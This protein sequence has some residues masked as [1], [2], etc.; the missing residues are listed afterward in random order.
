MPNPVAVAH[1]STVT[2][3]AQA[4][5]GAPDIAVLADGRYVIV[6]GSET[7]VQWGTPPNGQPVGDQD[8]WARILDVNGTGA[9]AFEIPATPDPVLPPDGPSSG[10][11]PLL[12]QV[13][14][15]VT[16]LAN[17]GFAVVWG[18]SNAV[19]NIQTV[20]LRAFGSTGVGGGDIVVGTR[21]PGG[22]GGQH[23]VAALT[24]GRLVVAW[25]QNL[26]FDTFV[27]GRLIDITGAGGASFGLGGIIDG[28]LDL[29]N[30]F[31]EPNGGFGIGFS[32]FA[33]RSFLFSEYSTAG[34]VYDQTNT[35]IYSQYGSFT[36]NGYQYTNLPTAEAYD[37][38]AG[39]GFIRTFYAPPGL[40]IT[41]GIHL[42]LSTQTSLADFHI[43]Y[44]R[45]TDTSVTRLA[46]GD[47]AVI[48]AAADRSING[49][50]V[51][52]AGALGAVFQVDAAAGVAAKPVVDALPSGGF[53]VAWNDGGVITSQVYDVAVGPDITTTAAF[54]ITENIT[55]AGTVA[56][57]AGQGGAITY[58]LAAA[59]GSND[60][61]LFAINAA[62]GALVFLTAP[63]FENPQ[64]HGSFFPFDNTYAVDVIATEAGGYSDSATIEVTVI[65][66]QNTITGTPGNDSTAL[67]GS[68][69]NG[70]AEE[71]TINALAGN[72]RLIG[73]GGDDILNG[74]A[75]A[76]R[77]EG[78]GGT[79]TATY[80]DADSGIVASLILT[81]GANGDAAGDTYNSIE[82][83]IGSGFNDLL[84]GDNSNNRIQGG[85]GYDVIYGLN[86]SNILEGGALDD[87]YIST[88]TDGI[89][90]IV[91]LFGGGLDTVY[92]NH[93]FALAAEVEQLVLFGTPA[94]GTGSDGNNLLAGNTNAGV[95]LDGAGGDDVI[96]GS[97]FADTLIGGAGNDVLLGDGGGDR[98]DGGA[99]TD[100]YISTSADDTFVDTGSYEGTNDGFDTVYASYNFVN[101]GLVQQIILFGAA[102][103]ATGSA[104]NDILVGA[105]VTGP[106]TLSGLDGWDTLFG[107]AQSGDV[108]TGGD[109]SDALIG[110]AGADTFVFA[111]GSGSDTIYDFVPTSRGPAHDL[112]D[113][114]AYNTNYEALT[115]FDFELAHVASSYINLPNVGPLLASIALYGVVAADLQESD[116]VFQHAVA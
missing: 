60:N 18:Q 31:A 113:L 1:G 81:S 8:V 25:T 49:R 23:E 47:F 108:L 34:A 98:F 94:T 52:S 33:F 11:L 103:A 105:N 55:A 72:D 87:I 19:N 62:T 65:N 61:A 12:Q 80:A 92:A 13:N 32:S 115:F 28:S 107:S 110:L 77:L 22:G 73:L 68:D 56:V 64:D 51:T 27:N 96:Y 83:L 88:T 48:W 74:G 58:S 30:V 99:G 86:G 102:T 14:P 41:P 16:A 21:I 66:V 82:N 100:V 46:N 89:D 78:G 101:A 57:Q 70:S 63:D 7:L 42:Q 109:E 45:A 91:E 38:L 85:G 79:D 75:G 114:T 93:N 50:L 76:D 116:F 44:E 43:S 4:G 35:Q 15:D 36:L 2:V 20:E 29:E 106:V 5:V 24:D 59:T 71:D 9:V 112:I 3:S 37:A 10:A 39:G 90:T 104:G 53:V 40:S 69:L 111:P 26:Q 95:T 17:G 54:I 6:Y 97:A 84:V 67:G